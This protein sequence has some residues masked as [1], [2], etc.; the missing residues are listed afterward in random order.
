MA[1]PTPADI[2]EGISAYFAKK[3]IWNDPAVDIG[4]SIYTRAKLCGNGM[5]GTRGACTLKSVPNVYAGT[6]YENLVP[7]VSVVIYE[8]NV[9]AMV[10]GYFNGSQLPVTIFE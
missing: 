6:A 8:N 1:A 5:L 3:G 2:I 9:G 10:V 4:S 7:K